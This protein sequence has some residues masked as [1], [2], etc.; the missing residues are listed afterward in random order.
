MSQFAPGF[1]H[2]RFRNGVLDQ[3]YVIGGDGPL[4]VLIHGFP[5]HGWMWRRLAQ[6][7]SQQF[8][9][10]VPD[11]RGMGGSTITRSGYDKRTL[12][13]DLRALV[14]HLGFET[15]HIVGYDVGGGTAIAYAFE[16]PAQ[17]QSLTVL[18]YAPPGFGFEYGFQ[19]TPDWQ[20]WQ[21]SFF[22]QPDVAVRFLQGQERELLSW[23]FWHWSANSQAV[24]QADFEIYVRELQK[25]GGLRGGFEHFAA[26]FEDQKLFAA[27][28]QAKITAPV[29]AIGGEFGAQNYP[30][31]AMSA[32]ATSAEGLVLASAGHWLVDEQPDQLSEALQ[33]FLTKHS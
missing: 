5:Q 18:E 10:L 8:T 13:Q 31:Q 30:V 19:P 17:T 22:T 15:A 16:Y 33:K 23:Y 12:A 7:L 4:V 6:D 29:L 24:S 3:H 11:Q 2:N 25:P 28:A 32:L 21:L 14:D 1:Q 20:S 9:V 26:V 27:Y